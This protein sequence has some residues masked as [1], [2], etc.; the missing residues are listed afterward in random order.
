MSKTAIPHRNRKTDPNGNKLSRKHV[1]HGTFRCER[2]PNSP[3]C[4]NKA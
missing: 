2:K 4:K 1:S 3:R